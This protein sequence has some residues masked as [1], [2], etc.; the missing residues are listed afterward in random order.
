MKTVPFGIAG[1]AAAAGLLI[2]SSSLRAQEGQP[3]PI[4]SR[5]VSA[6]IDYGDD[7]IFQ[8]QKQNTDFDRYGLDPGQVVTLT[9]WFPVELAGQSMMVEPLDG[10]LAS[11]QEKEVFVGSDGSVSFQ[12]TAGP[13]S[14]ACRIAVHQPDDS[15]FLQFWIIDPDHPENTPPDLLGNY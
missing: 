7:N 2:L 15:N 4:V 6:T 1:V 5:A 13:F 10:G 8:P 9:V 14:G 12:F 11:L 3:Q